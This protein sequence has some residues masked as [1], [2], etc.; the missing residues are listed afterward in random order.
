MGTD[1]AVGDELDASAPFAENPNCSCETNQKEGLTAAVS[2][3]HPKSEFPPKVRVLRL[4][5]T[6]LRAN[7]FTAPRFTADRFTTRY[8]TAAQTAASQPRVAAENNVLTVSELQHLLRGL[9]NQGCGIQWKF[10]KEK[11]SC[12]RVAEIL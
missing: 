2:L 11:K 6:A 10:L 12:C 3:R 4:R 8:G 5:V 1:A 9:S 7:G